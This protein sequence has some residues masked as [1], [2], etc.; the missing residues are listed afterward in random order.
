MRSRS[1]ETFRNHTIRKRHPANVEEDSLQWHPSKEHSRRCWCRAVE[2]RINGLWSI[3]IIWMAKRIGGWFCSPLPFYMTT[4]CIIVIVVIVLGH[5]NTRFQTGL[6]GIGNTR[7]QVHTCS[8]GEGANFR[9]TLRDRRRH[10][11]RRFIILEIVGQ[12]SHTD[13]MQSQFLLDMSDTATPRQVALGNCKENMENAQDLR[14]LDLG[15]HNCWGNAHRAGPIGRIR[16]GSSQTAPVSNPRAL[17]CELCEIR[18]PPEYQAASC[19]ENTFLPWPGRFIALLETH[20]QEGCKC[21]AA[22]LNVEVWATN[23]SND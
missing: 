6:G 19:A 10:V 21:C 5:L 23:W 1:L 12:R 17:H 3:H 11:R 4:S 14:T 13:L 18:I 15:T 20:L 2:R 7:D 16:K 8:H 22:I 9:S